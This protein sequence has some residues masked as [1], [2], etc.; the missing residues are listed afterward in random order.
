VN[1]K[2]VYLSLVKFPKFQISKGEIDPLVMNNY[3]IERYQLQRKFLF[4]LTN[5]ALCGRMIELFKSDDLMSRDEQWFASACIARFRNIFNVS[6]PSDVWKSEC[7]YLEIDGTIDFTFEVEDLDLYIWVD[8]NSNDINHLLDD[9][10][11]LCY[12]TESIFYEY[13]N[14]YSDESG[15]SKEDEE[16]RLNIVP[17]ETTCTSCINLASRL[18]N[19]ICS[20]YS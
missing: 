16:S 19:P 2:T 1:Y 10:K 18:N 7:Q 15:W 13:I 4:E 3:L 11:N 6:N 20:L 8:E 9:L 17:S 12:M 5:S 14:E